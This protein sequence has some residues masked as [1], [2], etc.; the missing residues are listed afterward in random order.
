MIRFLRLPAPSSGP[1]L[2]WLGGNDLV[3][4]TG[5]RSVVTTRE[6]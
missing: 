2:V 4:A 1:K 5:F 3:G 6:E